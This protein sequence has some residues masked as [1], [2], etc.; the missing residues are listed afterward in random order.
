[1]AGF[2]AIV[3]LLIGNF[4]EHS[5]QNIAWLFL[6][7]FLTFSIN[8]W[9]IYS[10]W[11]PRIKKYSIKIDKEHNWHGKKIVMI[12]D[13]HYGNIYGVREARLLV[14]RINA[15]DPEVVL[16]PGDFFDG[17]LIDYASIVKEFGCIRAHHGVLFAN[18]N[19][20]EYT[21]TKQ[22]LKTIKNPVL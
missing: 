18:G 21:H 20:E 19:H 22:I 15:L 2:I 4:F 7:L 1:M 14:E 16:I 8:A 13:T 9:G 6:F 5:Y 11:V 12:A 3:F 10:S 17:P